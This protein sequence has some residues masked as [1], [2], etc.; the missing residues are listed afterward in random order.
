VLKAVVDFRGWRSRSPCR[1]ERDERGA[2]QE[3][4]GGTG[5]FVVL[6]SITADRYHDHGVDG[7]EFEYETR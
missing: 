1:D 2:F 7:D 6:L 4:T 3:S 5:T